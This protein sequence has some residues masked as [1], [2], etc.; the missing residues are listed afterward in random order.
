MQISSLS[1]FNKFYD[2]SSPCNN[3]ELWHRSAGGGSRGRGAT[4]C[5]LRKLSGGATTT[6]VQTHRQKRVG[7]WKTAF[8]RTNKQ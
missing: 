3:G 8:H 1:A 6:T 4:A 5:L 2:E 7:T